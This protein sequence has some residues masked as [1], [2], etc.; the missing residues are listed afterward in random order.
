MST[1]TK[2]STSVTHYHAHPP[3][4][5]DSLSSKWVNN[6]ISQYTH[7]TRVL[8]ISFPRDRAVDSPGIFQVQPI[9]GG[10]S[11]CLESCHCLLS[12]SWERIT[13]AII[14]HWC[15]S[16]GRVNL[17]HP[18]CSPNEIMSWLLCNRLRFTKFVTHF[19]HLGISRVLLVMF[20]QFGRIHSDRCFCGSL[21][22]LLSP[23]VCR[24]Q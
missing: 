21:T 3:E 13:H 12:N 8:I 17:P 23:N 19:A 15:Y 2:L 9:G 7:P 11:N 24:S 5:I 20:S 14:A 4:D 16:S 22:I 1:I 10:S 18:Y 6:S